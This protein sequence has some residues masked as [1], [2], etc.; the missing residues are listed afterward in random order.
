MLVFFLYTSPC[1]SYKTLLT[2]ASNATPISYRHGVDLA[3]DLLVPGQGSFQALLGVELRVPA[4]VDVST[5]TRHI[6]S[7]EKHDHAHYLHF[8][9]QVLCSHH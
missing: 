8:F 4:L 6:F 5:S 7:L 9:Q 3:F 1:N 2:V